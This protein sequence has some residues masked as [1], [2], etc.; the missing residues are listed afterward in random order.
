MADIEDFG[1]HTCV[2]CPWHAYPFL[3][4]VCFFVFV[5]VFHGVAL[6]LSLIN[7]LDWSAW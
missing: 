7:I 4:V 6:S 3:L 2:K 5:P 1:G